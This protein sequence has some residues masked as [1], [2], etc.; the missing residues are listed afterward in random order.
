MEVDFGEVQEGYVHFQG[1]KIGQR[2]QDVRF[3][4]RS[5]EIAELDVQRPEV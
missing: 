3:L 5:I 2:W 4:G 1:L